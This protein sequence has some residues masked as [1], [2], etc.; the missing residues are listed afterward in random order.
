MNAGIIASSVNPFYS[1]ITATQYVPYLPNTRAAQCCC[2]VSFWS[3][4]KETLL[5]SENTI[6][7]S[8]MTHHFPCYHPQ[9]LS[10]FY[11]ASLKD[12]LY[13]L[14]WSGYFLPD[15]KA[16]T[17]ISP[18]DFCSGPNFSMV[19]SVLAGNYNYLKS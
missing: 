5:V 9:P 10:L 15:E 12:T 1:S 8:L 13:V 2:N 14:R 4:V 6:R 7:P 16:D 17:K 19:S 18:T 11:L 3:S